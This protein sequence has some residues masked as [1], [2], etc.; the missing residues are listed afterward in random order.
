MIQGLIIKAFY[1]YDRYCLSFLKGDKCKKDHC[2]FLHKFNYQGERVIQ[3]YASNYE[4]AL[5]M[6][7]SHKIMLREKEIFDSNDRN[8]YEFPTIKETLETMIS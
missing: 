1:G 3:G 6:L 5:E 2:Y 7:L 8:Y 4:K